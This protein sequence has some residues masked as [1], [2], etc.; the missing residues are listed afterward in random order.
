MAGAGARAR[1]VAGRADHRH[2]RCVRRDV[3]GIGQTD[4]ACGAQ[5][6]GPEARD[7]TFAKKFSGAARSIRHRPRHAWQRRI[8][9]GSTIRL[10]R[11]S[12]DLLDCNTLPEPR[13]YWDERARRV[14]F[15]LRARIEVDV[16][17][18][19]RAGLLRGHPP[20]SS[21]SKARESFDAQKETLHSWY[22]RELDAHPNAR[23]KKCRRSCAAQPRRRVRDASARCSWPIFTHDKGHDVDRAE[24]FF[25]PDAPQTIALDPSLTPVQNAERYYSKAKHAKAARARSAAAPRVARPTMQRAA[26]LARRIRSGRHAR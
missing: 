2:T 18:R 3:S 4:G 17:R 25:R 1:S 12:S 14:F 22:E 11:E 20:V 26:S 6:G 13:I 21:A 7:R 5:S 8:F 15:A 16:S 19:T 9:N 24:R 23:L 10:Y